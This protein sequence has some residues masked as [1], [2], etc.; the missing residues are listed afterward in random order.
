MRKVVAF[1]FLSLDGVAEAPD[2]FV[3]GW[4]DDLEASGAEL[5]S[6]QDAVVLGRRSYDEWAEFW[7]GSE[8]EPFATFINGVAKYVATSTPLE[9]EWTHTTVIDGDL[10]GFVRHLKDAPGGDI[11]VHA[12]ISV[13]QALL[14]AGLVDELRLTIAPVIV[15]SGRRLLDALPSIRLEPI[16]GVATPSGHLLADYRVIER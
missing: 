9:R 15:G 5:I 14:A 3:T 10:A 1:E 2:T 4:D 7:P 13:T 11:G 16:R 6:T 12:S 8:I